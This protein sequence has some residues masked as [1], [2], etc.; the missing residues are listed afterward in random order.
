[1]NSPLLTRPGSPN[2]RQLANASQRAGA[3]QARARAA[4]KPAAARGPET[5]VFA[6]GSLMWENAV[7]FEEARAALLPG[8]R[9]AFCIYSHVYRGTA[10]RPGLVLG[11]LRGGSCRGT[12]FRLAPET[13]EAVLAAIHAREMVTGVYA[14]R[15]LPLTLL[16]QGRE[17]MR[18]VKA[19]VFVADPKHAQFAGRLPPA[20]QAEILRE[21]SGA[22]GTARAYLEETVTHLRAQGIRDTELE[23]LLN[24]VQQ[25]EPV[26][27]G[28]EP[29]TGR[30]MGRPLPRRRLGR[31]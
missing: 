25:G 31:R 21:A 11:L 7:P 27:T 4:A 16:P 19:Y 15:V 22:R 1:M 5:W 23:R 14:L 12:A 8:F 2:R 24:L 29:K 6:Y 18:R 9:R 13:A 28:P 10:E 30:A 26:E 3:R 20:V 17:R